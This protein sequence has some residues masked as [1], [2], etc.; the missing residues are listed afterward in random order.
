ML[1][2]GVYILYIVREQRIL[3]ERGRKHTLTRRN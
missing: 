1:I 3:T 2:T